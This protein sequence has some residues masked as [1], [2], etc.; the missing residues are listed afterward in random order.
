MPHLKP[1]QILIKF[2]KFYAYDFNGEHNAIDISQIMN[3]S[4]EDFFLGKSIV[5]KQQLKSYLADM[6]Q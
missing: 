6:Y 4:D 1:S 5:D 3:K 2:L